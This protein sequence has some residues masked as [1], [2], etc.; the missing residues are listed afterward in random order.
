MTPK[1]KKLL[2]IVIPISIIVIAIIVI[3]ILYFTTD[4]LKSNKTLFLK[5]ISQDIDAAK[6]VIDN[7]SEKTYANTLRQNKYKADA[8]LSATYTKNANTSEENTESDINKL[9]LTI[10]E[11]SDYQA[12]YDYK[13][14]NLKYDNN[15][16]LRTEYIHSGELY[17]IGFP[18]MFNKSVSVQNGNLKEVAKKAGLTEEQIELVPDT[19]EEIDIYDMFSFT[20]D[21]IHELQTKY[22]NILADSI[23]ED[24]YSKTSPMIT[25]DETS[26]NTNAYSVTLTREQAGDIYVKIL[27]EIKDDEI[28]LNKLTQN[29]L[30]LLLYDVSSNEEGIKPEDAIKQNFTQRIDETI[31]KIQDNNMGTDEIKCT[32]YQV[33][34][35]TIRTTLSE[36]KQDI[37]IDLNYYDSGIM[38][39]IQ[40]NIKNE[41]EEN[42]REIKIEKNDTES[43]STF[44][45][46]ITDTVGL[47]I[48]NLEIYR[49]KDTNG[50]TIS[51]ENGLTYDDG[52]NNLLEVTYNEKV[53]IVE[54]LEKYITLDE[55]NNVILN[56]WDQ[57]EV[58]Q[59]LKLIS[60]KLNEKIQANQA[61]ISNIMQGTIPTEGIQTP[62]I[63]KTEVPTEVERNRFNAKFEFYTGSEMT[64]EQI[65]S[66][67]DEAQSSLKGAQVSYSD[68][69]STSAENKKL[70]SIRLQI[71][72]GV[73]NANLADSVKDLVEENKKYTVTIDYDST[74]GLVSYVTIT[75]NK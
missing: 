75:I 72:K 39:D 14:I 60:Q 4:F 49:N 17:A 26:V 50:D 47:E 18:E 20:D 64:Y 24:K 40:K 63:E 28:I 31:T 9:K 65:L 7:T 21:E 6:M 11:Q 59:I 32:V 15:T 30:L 36:E 10:N 35:K 66:L 27:E 53:N 3:L 70:Q 44:S 48:S 1:L 51:F 56:E 13:D 8:E 33:K 23:P 57:E 2:A 58:S 16:L 22:T 74:T 69:G 12:D 38:I 41:D 37:I 68:N 5:Y 46:S 29:K 62:V 54:Q 45:I 25:I 61:I 42:T 43:S 52:K 67:L 19:I 71:E 55:T 34:G 73:E